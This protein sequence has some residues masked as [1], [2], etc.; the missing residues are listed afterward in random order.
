M[1]LQKGDTI[2]TSLSDNTI[3]LDIEDNRVTLF[4]GSQFIVAGGIDF[5]EKKGIFEWQGG[6]YA[7]SIDKVPLVKIDD[8]RKMKNLLSDLMDNSYENFVKAMVS[9]ESGIENKEALQNAYDN[10][11]NDDI[12]GLIDD[13]FAK[14]IDDNSLESEQSQETKKEERV[15]S[16]INKEDNKISK[17]KENMP[18]GKKEKESQSIT[19]N[20]T[21][22]PK[23][24][25]HI[26][27]DGRDFKVASFSIASNDKDGNVKF[28]NC[29]AYDDKISQVENMKK[30]DFVHLFGKDK[31]NIGKGGKEYTS[32]NIYS[33]K[34]LNTKKRAKDSIVS[35]LKGLKQRVNKQG[36]SKESNK[37]SM[38][39]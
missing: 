29:Y 3:V 1:N 2:R 27:K 9:I 21:A 39:I 5:N 10:Y 17:E 22:D 35:E 34:L 11:M 14:Y 23:I 28:T 7:D 12:M 19:G 6:R 8:F 31:V 38:E 26:S 24:S 37:K 32:L 30:G 16:P 33:A 13:N 15:N 36:R 20:L 18:D 4:T 25:E